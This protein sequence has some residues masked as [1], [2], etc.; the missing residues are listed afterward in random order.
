MA[1]M[2]DIIHRRCLNLG[3]RCVI[4]SPVLSSRRKITHSLVESWVSWAMSSAVLVAITQ[5]LLLADFTFIVTKNS[6]QQRSGSV[7]NV[8]H[9]TKHH[10]WT[11]K[12]SWAASSC[13]NKHT[14]RTAGF[15]V[16]VNEC[17]KMWHALHSQLDLHHLWNGFL[18]QTPPTE[19]KFLH[20]WIHSASHKPV[21][22]VEVWSVTV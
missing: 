7:R 10:R 22:K 1:S 21:N 18:C 8:K 12:E 2:N 19:L 13:W 17:V 3:L 9:S 15:S 14:K 6:R 16:N 5:C 4:L 20:L 11:W